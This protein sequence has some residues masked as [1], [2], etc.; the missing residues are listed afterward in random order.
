MQPQHPPH[1]QQIYAH[2][3]QNRNSVSQSLKASQEVLS[4]RA[5]SPVPHSAPLPVPHTA[6]SPVPY[7][8]PSPVPYRAPS[9][10]PH[11]TPS[12]VP[13]RAPSP[14]PYT[15][16][17]PVHYIAPTSLPYDTTTQYRSHIAS[18]APPH[19]ASQ[20]LPSSST[21]THI[22]SRSPLLSHMQPKHPPHRQQ[23]YAHNAQ[24]RNSVSQ[25]LKAS[26]EVS[27]SNPRAIQPPSQQ[28]LSATTNQPFNN[29]PQT[30]THRPA[31]YPVPHSYSHGMFP[32]SNS[33]VPQSST[34]R[35][36]PLPP[37]HSTRRNSQTSIHLGEPPALS[38]PNS[39][40][41]LYR[42]T[43]AAT[44]ETVQ[45]TAT[46]LPAHDQ[47]HFPLL[48]PTHTSQ[49]LSLPTAPQVFR[50]NVVKIPPSH[51]EPSSFN[52]HSI[53]SKQTHGG[54]TIRADR[55][56]SSAESIAPSSRADRW[57]SIAEN[58]EP[59]SQTNRW[60]SITESSIPTRSTNRW[61]SVTESSVP[62]LF[63]NR[64]GNLAGNNEQ[65]TQANRRPSSV[66]NSEIPNGIDRR[67]S[68]SPN[69]VPGSRTNRRQSNSPNRVPDSRTNRRQSN[70]PN[71]APDSRTNRRQSSSG[72]QRSSIS[73]RDRA[74]NNRR[75]LPCTDDD[76][77]CIS[78][79]GI[80]L[81]VEITDDEPA[82]RLDEG[83]NTNRFR[84]TIVNNFR[85]S[86]ML[87]PNQP[88]DRLRSN[89]PVQSRQVSVA[90]HAQLRSLAN[91]NYPYVFPMIASAL[92][93]LMF[94]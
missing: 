36:Q 83:Q 38:S 7:R 80:P 31:S 40:P 19:K 2:N 79:D 53:T 8:A 55:R 60:E 21:P 35:A 65:T 50:Q 22:Q 42:T 14:A 67:Q 84:N 59:T 20:A 17:S 91:T 69:G 89:E 34:Y 76:E 58:N 63:T 5:S 37:A 32:Y 86:F 1:R 30:Y 85:P 27:S 24:N 3:A 71:R 10:V 66:A 26:Q 12:P 13:Y 68:N 81:P 41:S 73:G 44:H 16:P 74:S 49:P 9:P 62:T 48:Y 39:Q 6:P 45:L 18:Q 94:F 88:L 57:R 87:N 52:H 23:I 29:V 56:P 47:N 82:D 51:T 33:R 61:E 43:P 11:T 92:I 72:G 90:R 25:S 28:P 54:S 77:D 46:H 93:S 15:A 70:S 75:R 4:Y 64:W 78:G